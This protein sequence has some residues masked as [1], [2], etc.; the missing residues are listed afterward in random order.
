ML[1]VIFKLNLLLL[2]SHLIGLHFSSSFAPPPWVPTGAGA[3]PRCAWHACLAL[4]SLMS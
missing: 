3:P 4:V 1:Y 2:T